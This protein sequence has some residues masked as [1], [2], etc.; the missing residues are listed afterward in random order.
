MEFCGRKFAVLSID[1]M[2][3]ARIKADDFMDTNDS[4]FKVSINVNQTFPGILLA[5]RIDFSH[6]SNRSCNFAGLTDCIS[7][8]QY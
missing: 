1:C 2:I 4:W 7:M 5:A 3:K 8:Y 6:G